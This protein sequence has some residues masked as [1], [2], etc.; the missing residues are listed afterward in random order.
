MFVIPTHR[1]CLKSIISI[2][3][4]MEVYHN[5]TGD[6]PILLIL[7]NGSSQIS[8]INKTYFKEHKN[9]WNRFRVYYIKI[10]NTSELIEIISQKSNIDINVLNDL[11]IPEKID[12]GKI[13][14]LIYLMSSAL[15]CSSFHRR[16]SDCYFDPDYTK[17]NLSVIQETKFLNQPVKAVIKKEILDVIDDVSFDDDEKILIAGSNYVG[18]WN[19][20]LHELSSKNPDVAANLLEIC[21]IPEDSIEDQVNS[22][23]TDKKMEQLNKR[24]IL[25]T[26]FNVPDAPECGNMSM[27]EIFRWIPNFIGENGVGFDYFTYF[28]AFLFKV[29]IV[30]HQVRIPHIHDDKRYD[31]I[32]LTRYWLGVIKMVDFDLIYTKFI[33]NNYPAKLM[34]DE[35]GLKVIKRICKKEFP[36]CLEEIIEAISIDSRIEK[37]NSVVNDILIASGIEKY[38]SIGKKLLECRDS[39]L[40]S[41]TTEYH[42]SIYLQRI[43]TDLITAADGVDVELFKKYKL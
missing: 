1:E 3:H 27:S 15:K 26:S 43:W 42:K 5:Q 6:E 11:L 22:N 10:D 4:E 13:Y 28:M 31:N 18:N 41:L 23:Y 32:D 25:K 29:P 40:D 17:E 21:D 37:Y 30:F 20:D 9:E 7:D 36:D 19:I 12:Y 14:N 24:A 33:Q 35:K 2:L 38:V 34:K 39:V 16:D 8:S